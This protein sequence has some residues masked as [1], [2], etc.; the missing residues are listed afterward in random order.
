MFAMAMTLAAACVQDPAMDSTVKHEQS[1][2]AKFVNTSE[3]AMS[4]ELILHVDEE[5]AQLWLSAD[6]ATRSG[7]NALDQVAAELGAL[8]IEP[9]FNLKMNAEKKIARGMHRSFVVVFDKEADLDAAATK[10]AEMSQ[11]SRVQFNKIINRPQVFVAPA[12]VPAP[13][14]A[15]VTRAEGMPFTD[16]ML[17]N[18]WHYNNTGNTNMFQNAKAGEDIGAFGAWKYTTGHPDVIVAVVDEGVKHSHIDLAANMWFNE[19]EKNGQEGVDDDNNGYVDDIYGINA[20]KGNGKITWDKEGDTGHGTHVAGTVAAVNNNSKGVCGVAGGSGKDDG[21]RIMSI[22]IFDGTTPTTQVISSRGIDYATDMGACILQC[23]WGYSQDLGYISES[24]YEQNYTSELKAIR[25]FVDEAGCS[26]LKG[27]VAI[28]AAGNDSKPKS[29]YPAAFNEILSVTSYTPDGLPATY[30]NFG[31]GSNIA[32]PGGEYS[33]VKGYCAYDGNVLST[34]PRETKDPVYATT[35]GRKYGTDY[36]S[37]QGT[38]MACP[39]VSGVAAL[40]VSYAIENGM[41]LTSKKL[42][43]LL[44]SSVRDIDGSLVGTKLAY[45]YNGNPYNFN[46][47]N[48]KGGMGTGKLDALYAIMNLRGATCIP[49]EVNNEAKINISNYMGNGDLHIT[50]IKGYEI[51]EDTKERLGIQIDFFDGEHY[52]L[53][54]KPGI[55]VVKFKYVAGGEVVGGLQPDNSMATGGKLIEK[56]FVIVARQKNDNGGWL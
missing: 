20:V 12:P 19:A 32:A 40:L 7:D 43:E 46:I 49:V 28:F 21:A 53:C 31:P 37:M 29:D 24:S 48:H 44:T 16:P 17:P 56:E 13:A 52:I 45:D 50:A 5:T 4:G 33:Y 18:Q 22:Q 26:G 14:P 15:A 39:H 3:D 30:T 55:G 23:S 1:V 9:L 34:V 27:G 51:D 41:T 10:Y 11:V 35:D 2:E 8:S 36:A 25:R 38:S 6:V 47:A 54:T 42:Y